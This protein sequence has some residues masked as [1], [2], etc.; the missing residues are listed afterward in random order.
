MKRRSLQCEGVSG[1]CE[2][3]KQFTMMKRAFIFGAVVVVILVVAMFYEG[4]FM[5][6]DPAPSGN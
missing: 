4:F 3:G 1:W 6:G 2:S 5:H